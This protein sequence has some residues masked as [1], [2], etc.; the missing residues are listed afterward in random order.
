MNKLVSE[1]LAHPE[2]PLPFQIRF[3]HAN[4]EYIWIEGVM[5]N[6]LNDK[7]VKG[8]AFNY[9]DVTDRKNLEEQ[10]AANERRFRALI[11][12][13]SD[14]IVLNDE[15]SNILYQSPSVT[16]ILGYTNEERKGTT[17]LEYVHPDNKESFKDLYRKL[18]NAKGQ[19]LPFQYRFLHKT[20]K[21][22]WLEGVVTNLIHD[23]AV[24]AYVANYRDITERKESEEKLLN[25]RALL[26]TLIDNIP[27]YI[28]VKDTESRH[29]INNKAMVKLLGASSEE[30]T[31][32]K[33]SIEFFGAKVATPYLAEDKDIIASG[34]AKFNFEET[35]I[36]PSGEFLYLRTTKV[37]LIDL[38][39][40]TTGLVGISHDITSQKQIELD[41]RNSKYFLEKAQ[42]VG[43]T[44][45]WIWDIQDNG[46]LVMS[47]EACR[48]FEI[49]PGQFD[50]K[51]Q[52]LYDFTHPDDLAL[53]KSSMESSINNN[54]SYSIDHR[55]VL[56]NGNIKWVHEQAETTTSDNGKTLFLIGIIQ[57]ITERKKRKKKY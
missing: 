31:L 1:I 44:G 14:A 36:A 56:K 20:G 54:I 6:L 39:G 23:P 16:R 3:L 41:L 57:D 4:G 18:R 37:P 21:Y 25:G 55:I 45:H 11:E 29:L 42:Q 26:R 5:T 47:T 7:N 50:E 19:P 9:R 30:E 27:D 46:K 22:I 2:T 32:G 53:V 15:N 24:N 52:A 43:N 28:Y 35:T 10:Q 33:S 12:N 51:I 49:E 13:I 40:N 17:V 8:I 34:V 48:I 38:Q